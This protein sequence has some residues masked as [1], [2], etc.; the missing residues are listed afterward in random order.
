LGG[1]PPRGFKSHPY[2][3][4]D[5]R[6]EGPMHLGKTRRII[7]FR[8]ALAAC[9]FLL[10]LGGPVV[11][12]VS[13]GSTDTSTQSDGTI[14]LG[15]R[16]AHPRLLRG[17]TAELPAPELLASIT[18]RL[19]ITSRPG[20]GRVIGIMPAV[21]VYGQIPI[22]AWVMATSADGAYGKVPVP[23]RGGDRSGWISLK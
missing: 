7:S 20:G 15:F 3:S 5:P 1:Q 12:R 2:R 18:R 21:S 9:A 11:S 16:T 17:E 10:L 22:V 19:R 4:P 6:G 8:A 13:K 23:F 14:D